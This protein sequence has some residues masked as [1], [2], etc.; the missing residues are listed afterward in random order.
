MSRKENVEGSTDLT[1]ALTYT[2]S[3]NRLKKVADTGSD[4]GFKDG[5][6]LTEEYLYND[7]GNMIEDKNKEIASIAYNYLNLPEK[8]TFANVGDSIKYIYDATGV[9]LAQKVYKSGVLD[10]TTDYAGEFIYED[11]VLQFVQHE[12]GRI[13]PNP[14]NNGTDLQYQY[15]LKDHLGNVR[16]SFTTQPTTSL[17]QATMELTNV[18]LEEST[19]GNVS[20][21]RQLDEA[22]SCNDS[23]SSRLNAAQNR[24]VGPT[25]SLQVMAQDTVR[26]ET[27]SRYNTGGSKNRFSS[28]RFGQCGT[29]CL[30]LSQC[31]G[32]VN[33]ISG[34]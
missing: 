17:Y 9:K 5:V 19:F 1:D 11:N 24:I 18:T 28:G 10:K 16:V 12:E 25:I 20:S 22:N 30:W 7:N 26:I 29:K 23:R 4:G 3:G 2:Y 33:C 31:R 27:Y 13:V 34:V 14:I 21:T 8:I 6:D 32:G 15:H